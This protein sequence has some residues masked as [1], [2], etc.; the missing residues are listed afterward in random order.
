M[1]SSATLGT[2]SRWWAIARADQHH[3]DDG[4]GG[5]GPGA[6]RN[7]AVTLDTN[8]VD[9]GG[10]LI[11]QP[12]CPTIALSPATLPNGTVAVAYSQTLVGS[13]GTAPYTFALTGGTLPAGLTLTSAGVLAGTPTAA[14]TSSFTIRATDANGCFA[15]FARTLVVTT[16]V[17]TVPQS[18]CSSSAWAHGARVRRL[19]SG[20][21]T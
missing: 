14:G 5:D 13:G 15:D 1:T 19:A 18:P 16:A 3:A 21:A 12:G 9:A 6:G 8:T 2:N 17:P 20:R 11:G 7:G 4:R 10:C